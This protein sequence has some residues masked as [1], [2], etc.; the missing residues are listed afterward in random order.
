MQLQFLLSN[1][2]DSGSGWAVYWT[3]DTAT[4]THSMGKNYIVGILDHSESIVDEPAAMVT[5]NEDE[6]IIAFDHALLDHEVYTVNIINFEGDYTT[7]SYELGEFYSGTVQSVML[8]CKSLNI[9]SDKLSNFQY[10]KIVQMQRL[11]DDAIDGYLNEYYFTPLCP[12]NQVQIDGSVR[13][14]FPGKI[15]FL[16]VQWTAGLLL[17]TEFQ[18]LE[19][20]INEQSQRFVEEA[21]KEMQQMVDFSTR[22][23]GQRRKHPSPTMPPNLAPSK[24]NEFQL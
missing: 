11:V 5:R 20:N 12:F 8:F 2:D 22:I 16:A 17:Q 14:L 3:G 23:P 7:S 4:I 21:K 15:R 10:P 13:K 18:N 24:T 6:L 19:P 9:S 1:Q